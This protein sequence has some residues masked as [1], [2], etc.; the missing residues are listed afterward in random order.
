[1]TSMPSFVLSWLSHFR[2]NKKTRLPEQISSDVNSEV[3]STFYIRLMSPL[4]NNNWEVI[5][6]REFLLESTTPDELIF[7]LKAR[8]KLLQ[9]DALSNCGSYTEVYYV[10]YMDALLL[11]QEVVS[12]FGYKRKLEEF[13]KRSC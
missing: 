13:L 7:Y 6:F 5:A 4:L 2:I 11:I 8:S 1:M 9:G 10:N 3:L 12:D